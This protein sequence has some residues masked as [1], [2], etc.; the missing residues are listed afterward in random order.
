MR[1][2]IIFSSVVLVICFAVFSIK[3]PFSKN[4]DAEGIFK[5][6]LRKYWYCP[7]SLLFPT[8]EKERKQEKTRKD[9]LSFSREFPNSRFADDAIF[10]LACFS[11]KSDDRRMY[12]KE[13][14]QYPNE[15]L[16]DYTVEFIR[17]ECVK[18]SGICE[19]ILADTIMPYDLVVSFYKGEQAS[20]EKDYNNTIKYMGY[21]VERID[22]NNQ[23]LKEKLKFAYIHLLAGYKKTGKTDE[24]KQISEKMLSLYPE[25]NDRISRILLNPN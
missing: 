16:E 7:T 12:M 17:K 4:K 1:K 9:L 18:S 22:S 2:I 10:V 14:E 15:K 25:E 24:C 19:Y 20:I 3:I 8:P 23:R 6:R 11:Q 13:L 5:D 21:F